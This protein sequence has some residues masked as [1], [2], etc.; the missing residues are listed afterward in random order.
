MPANKLDALPAQLR[1]CA[2]PYLSDTC[3][4]ER[5]YA[6]HTIG[7][8]NQA[9]TSVTSNP[10]AFQVDAVDESVNT[11]AT[12]S[13]GSQPEKSGSDSS[14]CSRRNSNSSIGPDGDTKRASTFSR[15]LAEANSASELMKD[16]DDAPAWLL[17]RWDEG[18]TVKAYAEERARG[19]VPLLYRTVCTEQVLL[20]NADG[21]R[22]CLSVTCTSLH[23][24]FLRY[25]WRAHAIF[26]AMVEHNVV[27]RSGWVPGDVFD[28]CEHG[29]STQGE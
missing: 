8:S 10:P 9:P 18:T 5:K 1:V 25:L 6:S 28:C 13:Q 14:S 20:S 19:R 4:V 12:A 21:Q 22:G 7:S 15:Q 2:S 24:M 23:V 29:Q 27:L 11:N 16:A 17:K 26:M 3:V